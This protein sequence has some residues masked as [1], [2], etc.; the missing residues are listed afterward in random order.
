MTEILPGTALAA[1]SRRAD[2]SLTDQLT[3]RFAERIR[4]HLLAPGARLPSV[5]ECARRHGV[6]P[7]TVEIGRA[8]V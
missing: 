8:H 3:A 6:S 1:L 5:R 2:I 4:Q 7:T